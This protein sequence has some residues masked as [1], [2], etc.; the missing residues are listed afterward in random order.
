LL[1]LD[2]AVKVSAFLWQLI[3]PRLRRHSRALENL[4]IAYPEKTHEEREAIARAMWANLGR[5]M[6]ETM[7]MDRILADPS[8]IKIKSQ[9]FDRYRDKVGPIVGVS[10]HMGNWEL[11]IWPLAMAGKDPAA[12]YRKVNNPYVDRFLRNQRR[13]LYPGGLFAKG[14]YED[15]ARVVRIITDFVK[16]GG[17]LGIVSDL[18]DNAGLAVPFFGTPAKSV[19]APALIARRTGARI[20]MARCLRIGHESRFEIDM[21]ELKVPR[22]SNLSDDIKTTTAAMQQQFEQWI[23][24]TPEQWMWSNR[25]WS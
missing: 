25:R 1:P 24:E 17:R 14:S 15:S 3:A 7:L 8:R 21:L 23:R 16:S 5:V 2:R 13:A 18:H 10:L 20:W 11:A 19:I 4:A 22:T 9:A 12:I 6:A